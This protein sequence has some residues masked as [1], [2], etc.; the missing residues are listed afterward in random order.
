MGQLGLRLRPVA[1]SRIAQALNQNMDVVEQAYDLGRWQPD[2]VIVSETYKRIAIVD[3]CRSADV[4]PNQLSAV[5]ARKQQ[6]Y[7]V[8]VEALEYY[9]D[10]G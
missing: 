10:L 8:L 1:I 3:L 4:H 6:K 7:S 5:G 9:A 2:W